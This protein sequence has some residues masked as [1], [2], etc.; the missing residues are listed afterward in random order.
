MPGA[1]LRA[2]LG[3]YE[4]HTVSAPENSHFS[5]ELVLRR[6]S[7]P[8]GLVRGVVLDPSGARVEG[9]RVS[10]RL[11]STASSSDGEFALDLSRPACDRP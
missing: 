11:E 1:R 5:L 2:T 7:A 4:P 10:A 3:G 8:E 9:A 6:P